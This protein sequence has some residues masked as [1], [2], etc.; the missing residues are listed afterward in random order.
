MKYSHSK[1]SFLGVL[2]VMLIVPSLASAADRFTQGFGLGATDASTG[3]QVTL[4]QRL[5]S[6]DK[7]IYPEGIISGY[8]GKLT[9]LAVQKWQKKYNIITSGTPSTTGFGW[10]GPR[11]RDSLNSKVGALPGM[12]GSFEVKASGDIDVP[13]SLSKSSVYT[14]FLSASFLG[15]GNGQ[16]VKFTQTSPTTKI[17]PNANLSCGT[18][19]KIENKVTVTAGTPAGSYQIK[20][21]AVAGKESDIGYYN[22]IV[23]EAQS[24]QFSLMASGTIDKKKSLSGS[25]S[26]SNQI[27]LRTVSGEPQPVKVIQKT[28]I[29]GLTVKDLGTC[30]PPCMLTNAVTMGLDMLTGVYPVT[31]NATG[32]G[33][34]RTATYNVILRYNEDFGFHISNQADPDKTITMT[35]P[36]VSAVTQDVPLKFILDGGTPQP[37]RVVLPKFPNGVSASVNACMLPCE[38]TLHITISPGILAGSKSVS[39]T[40]QADYIDRLTGLKKTM[41]KSYAE[42]VKVVNGDQLSL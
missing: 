37:T 26:G 30:T 34:S 33:A 40:L 12:S 14:N 31:V 42:T 15:A 2:C 28:D 27:I 22:V 4:L 6:Q 17:V 41:S 20:V 10:V 18:P 7:T 24:F 9:Q 21:S 1:I 8:F 19:C 35:V 16:M 39:F 13:A 23:G 3:G 29:S 25:V 38:S 32:G 11:T 36:A 5:L